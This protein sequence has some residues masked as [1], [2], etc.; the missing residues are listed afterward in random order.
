MIIL[1]AS[2]DVC[3]WEHNLF[4]GFV[5]EPWQIFGYIFSDDADVVRLVSKVMPLVASFQVGFSSCI[6]VVYC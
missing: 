1:M 3:L 5:Y 6:Y 4:V 2:K